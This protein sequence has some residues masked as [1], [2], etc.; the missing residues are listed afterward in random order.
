MSNYSSLF[1]VLSPSQ[2]QT[3]F[4]EKSLPARSNVYTDIVLGCLILGESFFHLGINIQEVP[5]ISFLKEEIKKKKENDF[6]GIDPDNLK[7]WKVEIP[8]GD[9]RL[10]QLMSNAEIDIDSI[11]KDLGGAV[12]LDPMLNIT[13]YFPET[14]NPPEEHVHI[15]VQPPKPATTGKRKMVE[16]EDEEFRAKKEKLQQQ[17]MEKFR[18]LIESLSTINTQDQVFKVPKLPGDDGDMAI[19]NRTC[20]K[21]LCKFILEDKEYKRYLVTGNPGVGKTFFGRLMLIELLKN[22]KAVL[23][24]YETITVWVY[25]SGEIYKIENKTLYRQIAEQPDVWCIIDGKRDQVGHDFSN[26]KLIM[27]S[28]PKKAI[29]GDFAK[30]WCAELFM[31][32]WNEDELKDCW[33]HLY[34]RRLTLKSLGDK[35]KLCGGIARWIFTIS[36]ENIEMAI[37]KAIKT[38]KSEILFHQGQVLSGDEY[39]HKLIHIHTNIEE[40]G[41]FSPYTTSTCFFASKYVAD[42]CLEQLQLNHKKELFDFI[43]NSKDIT[44]L[45]GFRGTLFEMVAHTIIRQGGDF[46]VRELTDDG[47]G[48]ESIHSFDS[49]EENFFDNI[50]EIQGQVKYFRP[51]SKTF[52]SIDSYAHTNNLFQVTVSRKH[53]IKQDGLRA[54]KGILDEDFDVRIYFVL[55]SEIFRTFK[56]K[57]S[58]ENKGEGKVFDSWIYNITQ[59]ALCVNLEY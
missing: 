5:S 2:V 36:L 54:I 23:L 49:L 41:K 32:T 30:Q 24:D 57:Q 26:G 50:G 27:V 13:R 48:S 25:P 58:Y 14:Y 15:L 21:Y 4:E 7:L 19:Y 53:S 29:I 34:E 35:F 39:T 8:A 43:N 31:P 3:K 1:R 12:F 44:Q 9:N 46:R 38:V 56:R 20:Y 18:N 42:R 51:T 59:Y 11:A 10:K 52:E 45:G 33:K 55:P 47:T 16:D 28:S 17:D 37:E 40:M 6:R 22:N